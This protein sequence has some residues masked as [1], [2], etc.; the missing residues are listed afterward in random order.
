MP[1]VYRIF[2]TLLTVSIV[3]V[4]TL[5]LCV[6]MGAYTDRVNT[7]CE[8]T[9]VESVYCPMMNAFFVQSW[10]QLSLVT[11]VQEIVALAAA[12]LGVVI[13]FWLRFPARPPDSSVGKSHWRTYAHEHVEQKLYH[14]FLHIFARGIVHSRR[15]A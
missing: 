8:S 9:L 7:S 2:V 5:G 3:L 14:Y 4:G 13:A 12:A 11:T 15:F 6:R 10:N 1:R